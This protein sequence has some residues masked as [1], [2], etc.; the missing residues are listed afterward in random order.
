MRN[1]QES[2]IIQIFITFQ[3]YRASH[4]YHPHLSGGFDGGISDTMIV[5]EARLGSVPETDPLQD[6]I[7]GAFRCDPLPHLP[8]SHVI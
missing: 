1:M 2:L 3:P 4:E 8:S 5:T 7:L 6:H